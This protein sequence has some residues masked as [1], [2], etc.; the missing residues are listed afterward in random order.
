MSVD[1]HAGDHDEQLQ[2]AILSYLKAADS[3]QPISQH[4]LLTRYPDLTAELTAFF[5]DQSQ[6]DP[7][8]A[9]LRGLRE[10]VLPR[11][12]GDFRLLREVGHGGMGVVYEA[13][14]ISL[15]R[16]V[17]L[18]VLTQ[19]LLRHDRQKRRFEREARAAARLHH[20]NIVPVFGTGEAEGVLYYVMQ[21][22]QGRS[23]DLVIEELA[24]MAPGSAAPSPGGSEPPQP[25]RDLSAHGAA[26]LTGAFAAPG[27]DEDP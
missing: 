1:T 14:Q 26:L 20:T 6:L 2:E 10:A 7:V 19:R 12:L 24:R 11:L 16:R 22:I 17:A 25:P 3:G 21:F 5:V 15:G 18:K 9:P 23:L 13:E 4:E 27:G 8:L